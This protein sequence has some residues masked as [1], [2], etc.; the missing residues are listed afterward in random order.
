MKHL[1]DILR[2]R[3]LK[4]VIDEETVIPTISLSDMKKLQW[5]DEWENILLLM[6]HRMIMGGY[7][8][9]PT[10]LQKKREFDNISDIKRRLELYND[11]GNMEHLLDAAN[12]TI[13]ECLKQSH[14]NFHFESIDDGV[15]TERIK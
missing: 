1:H 8:Y 2:E 7:R 4:T 3:L 12:I 11:T 14:P 15:H 6:Q 9:G 10:K 5:G 13:I